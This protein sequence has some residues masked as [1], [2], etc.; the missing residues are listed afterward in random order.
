MARPRRVVRECP[1]KINLFLEI[2]GRRPD[3]YH[4]LATVMAP[5][6]VYDTLEV[7]AA[8]G[9][10]LEVEG[11]VLP[12]VNLV[13]KAFR[14]AARRAKI[15]GARVRLVKR[16]PAGS[17]LGG[18]SSDAA[19]MIEALDELYGLGLD[20]HAVAAEIGS[21]LNLFL[22]RRPALCTGRGERVAP[23][24]F[25]LSA[26]AVLVWPGFPLPTADVFRRAR[27]FLTLRPRSVMDFLNIAARRRPRSLGAALFNRLERPAF[28][29]RPEL[30]DWARRLRRWPFQAVRMTGSGSALFGLCRT[31]DEARSLARKVAAEMDAWVA[32]VGSVA[33]ED[34]WRSRKSASS[35]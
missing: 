29:L 6:S 9:F 4:D 32:P 33:G 22:A 14:A 25:P 8:R 10:R 24:A 5:V 19:A 21:D 31:S 17:G 18:G 13:E 23:L 30:A 20:R 16:V 26:H 7:R 34:V 11:A 15:P 28:S 3:G 27:E 35:S 12:G 2:L 1:A